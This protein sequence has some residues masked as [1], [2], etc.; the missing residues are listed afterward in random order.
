MRITVLGASGGTGRAVTHE[1]AGRGHTVTAVSRSGTADVPDG[2]ARLAADLSVPDE[3]RRACAGADVVV[4][5][6]QPPYQDWVEQWPPLLRT[7][8]AATAAAGA[9]LVFVDNLY[10]YAPATGPLRETSPEHATDHK[11]VLRRELGHMLLAASERGEPRATIG[12]FSDYYGPGGFHSGLYMVG[13]APALRGMAP[14]GLYDLDQP[15]TFHYLPDA[16]RGF[17]ELV[18]RPE[19]DGRVWLLPA[20]PPITQRELLGLV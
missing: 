10:A 20:A 9:R 16:A 14:R 11:G 7:V 13:I 17:A 12:R 5:A 3:A 18:E 4:L 6:A 1:L 8:M 2:V 15:H 19:A